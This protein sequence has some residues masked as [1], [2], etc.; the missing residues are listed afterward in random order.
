MDY[1]QVQAEKDSFPDTS[2][3]DPPE[4]NQKEGAEAG[5]RQKL[6]LSALR[7][8]PVIGQGILKELVRSYIVS[9]GLH[10]PPDRLRKYFRFELN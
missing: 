9:C 3:L 6:N 2:V 10:S 4:L 5:I 1:Y 8:F 7:P